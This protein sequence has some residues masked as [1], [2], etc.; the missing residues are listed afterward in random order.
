M[1]RRPAVNAGRE[2]DLAHGPIAER[3]VEAQPR[4]GSRSGVV[5]ETTGDR[6]DARHRNA[7]RPR[8][9][10]AG[11][12]RR[13]RQR[14]DAAGAREHV[15]GAAHI[16]PV[17]QVA[18]GIGFDHVRAQ[19]PLLESVFAP[20]SLRHVFVD[21]Q[22]DESRRHRGV[23]RRDG[24]RVPRLE[25]QELRAALAARPDAVRNGCPCTQRVAAGRARLDRRDVAPAEQ[26]ARIGV[27]QRGIPAPAGAARP[28]GHQAEHAEATG[29][30]QIAAAASAAVRRQQRI[31]AVLQAQKVRCLVRPDARSAVEA[32]H[33]VGNGAHAV[34]RHRRVEEILQ[35]LHD[36]VG[37]IVLLALLRM[38]DEHAVDLPVV[39]GGAG[40]S[41]GTVIV[42]QAQV[43][44]GRRHRGE[45][46]AGQ[47][48]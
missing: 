5:H 33:R 10:V 22:H 7:A 32:R 40:P 30:G 34:G 31:V 3:D 16:T 38:Q 23:E 26:R 6:R 24:G 46:L 14:R 18:V 27:G 11:R 28:G 9:A 35:R 42:G 17:A 39:V 41:I 1:R 25:Q 37:R 21:V 8:I 4:Q 36:A 2:G 12:V 44:A 29:A 47:S 19:V 45:R 15:S 43:E 48:P 20:A 13:R